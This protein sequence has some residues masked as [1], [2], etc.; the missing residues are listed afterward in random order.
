MFSGA[1]TSC[2][3]LVFVKYLKKPLG[4]QNIFY[5]GGGGAVVAF[6]FNMLL[7]EKIDLERMKK[8][9]LIV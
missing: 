4:Y 9:G 6:V 2:C 3:N 5:I 8:K 1:L 7:D